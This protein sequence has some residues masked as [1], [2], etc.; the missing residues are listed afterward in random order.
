MIEF[1]YKN[2]VYYTEEYVY[3]Y[4][5][6]YDEIFEFSYKE[7][8]K[9]FYNIA[10]KR[11]IEDTNYFDLETAY[12]YG[13][14]FA[15][16]TDM[17]FIKKAIKVYEERCLK[18]NIVAEFIRFHPFNT[19][20]K[21]ESLFDFIRYDR[22]VV[23]VNLRKTKEE[24]WKDYDS[25]TRNKLR[26]AQKILKFSTD[27]SINDFIRL[28]KITMDKNK[29]SKFYYFSDDYF[30]SLIKNVNAKMFCVLYKDKIVSSAVFLESKH[31]VSSHLS[32]SDYSQYIPGLNDFLFDSIFDY[33]SKLN[34]D[35]ALLGGG[36]TSSKE[37]SLFQFKKKFSEETL[38]F[39]IGGKIFN[40][41]AY[42]FLAE[43]FCKDDR[44][45]LKWRTL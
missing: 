38:P 24:R 14:W 40:R 45:F 5:K 25:T 12:G 1:N 22:D 41:E 39:Y 21:D 29:A 42:K 32:G 26:K 18:E 33:Y 8:E 36:K 6:D 43:N 34:K 9:E 27:C 17:D 35:Y 15:N 28:Y 19:F 31:I 44:I 11:P 37:D 2:C 30:K 16:T 13:G 23:I 4:L 10:I 20:P 3:L 7:G